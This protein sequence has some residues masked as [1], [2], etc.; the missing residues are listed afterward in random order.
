LAA[1]GLQELGRFPICK[2]KKI[3]NCENI[4]SQLRYRGQVQFLQ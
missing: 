1:G 3:Y 4:H 2:R